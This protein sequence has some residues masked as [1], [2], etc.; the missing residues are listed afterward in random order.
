[1][2]DIADNDMD[3]NVSEG[4]R[5]FLNFS[6]ALEDGDE[7]DSNFGG[8][9]VSFAIGDGSLLPGFER[10]IIGMQ[11]GERKLFQVPPEEAFGQPN[12]NNVQ[13]VPRDGF[14]ED[15]ELELGLVC[16]FADAS[17]GE[18]PGMIVGFDDTEVTVDFNH[19]LAGRTILFDVQIH[20]LE[21]VDLH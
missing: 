14:D 18:L 3:G 5:V 15:L 9:A 6:L 13:R 19:P 21:A 2:S 7:V 8:E 20:R 4:T 12:E 1:M 17:G 10:R 11:S 16:S